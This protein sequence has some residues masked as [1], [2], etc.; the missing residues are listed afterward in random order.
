MIRDP[1]PAHRRQTKYTRGRNSDSFDPASTFV[2]PDMRVLHEADTRRYPRPLRHDDVVVVPAFASP[3]SYGTLL[4]EMAALQARDEEGS[5]YV[6]WHEGCHL[7]IKQPEKSPTFRALVDRICDYFDIDPSTIAVRYNYYK[8]DV[9]WKSAH[10]DSAAFN[11]AR[12]RRHVTVG[13]SLGRTRELAFKHATH[14]TLVYMPMPR[15]PLLLARPSTSASSTRS[16]P[17]RPPSAPTRAASASSSGGSR[18]SPSTSPTSR[19]SSRR[20]TGGRRARRPRSARRRA[21]TLRAAPAASAQAVAFRTR[22]RRADR[23]PTSRARRG[24]ARPPLAA[25]CGPL[26]CCCSPRRS[27]NASACIIKIV[28]NPPPSS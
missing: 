26:F 24:G 19:R 17:S 3:A 25:G 14:G 28:A 23:R 27:R 22:G 13:L 9:D 8:D 18:A 4:D 6:S 20:P 7:L 11:K 15:Q 21:A 1:R 10:H 5:E 12:A 16:T 2:R